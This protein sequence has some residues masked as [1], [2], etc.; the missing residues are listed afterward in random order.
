[1]ATIFIDVVATLERSPLGPPILT[2]PVVPVKK[3]SG[4]ICS[5]G[6]LQN[7]LFSIWSGQPFPDL[8]NSARHKAAAGEF[9][10]A[11]QASE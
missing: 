5:N 7:H 8:F 11:L 1:M 2:P 10:Q 6:F 4:L 3:A 9:L